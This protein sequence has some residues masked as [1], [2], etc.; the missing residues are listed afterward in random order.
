M[1]IQIP[2]WCPETGKLRVANVRPIRGRQGL[3]AIKERVK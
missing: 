2:G 1:G 3:D